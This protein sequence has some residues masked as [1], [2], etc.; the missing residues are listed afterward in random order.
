M[1]REAFL[2]VNTESDIAQLAHRLVNLLRAGNSTQKF[3]AAT[4]LVR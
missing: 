4:I 2:L 1:W 3:D